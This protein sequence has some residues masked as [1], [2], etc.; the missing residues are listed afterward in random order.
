VTVTEDPEHPLGRALGD[1]LVLF[2]S[3]SGRGRTRRVP[4]EA[5]HGRHIGRMHHL[6]LLHRGE[7]YEQLRYWLDL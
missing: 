7:V 6:D 1:L 4:F 5:G 2:P 3:A